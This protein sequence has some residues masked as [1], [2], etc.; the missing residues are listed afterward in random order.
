MSA[1]ESV[2]R[3][4]QTSDLKEKEYEC[5]LDRVAALGFVPR[6]GAAYLRWSAGHAK[7]ERRTLEIELIKEM[8]KLARAR[9]WRGPDQVFYRMVNLVLD[10]LEKPLC[11]SCIGRG[12]V[13]VDRINP[14]TEAGAARVCPACNG[15]KA[16]KFSPRLRAGTVKAPLDDWN[17]V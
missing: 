3:A 11:P 6:L 1:W 12:M 16:K 8:L 2:A 5:D 9:R 17:T 14:K 4:T 10:E 7:S 15:L 13:G